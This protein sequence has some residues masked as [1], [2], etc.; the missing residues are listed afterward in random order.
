MWGADYSQVRY[1][2]EDVF[3]RDECPDHKLSRRISL[4]KCNKRLDVQQDFI[5][6]VQ[7]V[8]DSSPVFTLVVQCW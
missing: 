7:N 1:L 5:S 4:H 3:P 6:W 8:D 2:W